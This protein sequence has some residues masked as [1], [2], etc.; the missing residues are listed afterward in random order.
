MTFSSK[1]KNL[2]F[3]LITVYFLYYNS[4]MNGSLV[5]SSSHVNCYIFPR[6]TPEDVFYRQ[7]KIGNHQVTKSA[8]IHLF[9]SGDLEAPQVLLALL[10]KV[11]SILR[12]SEKKVKPPFASRSGLA[13]NHW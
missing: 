5:A 13:I 2:V 11:I 4:K 9:F 7:G 10:I 12:N 1:T 3:Y 8:N 6:L